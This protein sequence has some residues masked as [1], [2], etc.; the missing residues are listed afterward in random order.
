MIVQLL[1]SR[2]IYVTDTPWVFERAITIRRSIE[3]QTLVIISGTMCYYALFIPVTSTRVTI[4]IIIITDYLLH[5]KV[6]ADHAKQAV[7]I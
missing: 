1:E 3:H 6:S 5:S 2:E 4:I 7:I